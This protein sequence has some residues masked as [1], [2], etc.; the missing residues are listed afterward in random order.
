MYSEQQQKHIE[1][2]TYM[3]EMAILSDC[4]SPIL[5]LWLDNIYV[6]VCKS[7]SGR[8]LKL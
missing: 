7:E 8:K 2:A 5:Q 1:E 3:S 4:N 6:C